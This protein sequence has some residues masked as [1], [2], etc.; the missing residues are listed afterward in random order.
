MSTWTLVILLIVQDDEGKYGYE[1]LEARGNFTSYD[2][3]MEAGAR[4]SINLPQ[5]SHIIKCEPKN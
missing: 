5:S 2:N 1:R 4:Q 3:C